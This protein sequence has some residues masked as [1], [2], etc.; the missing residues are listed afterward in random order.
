MP[1]ARFLIFKILVLRY[2]QSTYIIRKT[3]FESGT[4]ITVHKQ[5][6]ETAL[7]LKF[8]SGYQTTA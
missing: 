1:D 7:R 4:W 5:V 3:N 8:R 2:A 6:L